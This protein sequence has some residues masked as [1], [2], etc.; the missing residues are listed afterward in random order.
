MKAGYTL[1]RAQKTYTAAGLIMPLI[2][3]GLLFLHIETV[4]TAI[5]EAKIEIQDIVNI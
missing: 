3:V 1:G 4:R 2:A 5:L